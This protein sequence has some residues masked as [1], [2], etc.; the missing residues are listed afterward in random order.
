MKKIAQL[1]R[2]ANLYRKKLLEKVNSKEKKLVYL[3]Q[4]SLL[5]TL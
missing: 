3:K 5:V 4:V 2:Y 1:G